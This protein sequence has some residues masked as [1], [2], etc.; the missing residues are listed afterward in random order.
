MLVGDIHLY[1]ILKKESLHVESCNHAIYSC[2]RRGPLGLWR[3]RR[4][5]GWDR[6]DLFLCLSRLVSCQ[7][8]R[9]RTSRQSTCLNRGCRTAKS[10]QTRLSFKP[11]FLPFVV[12]AIVHHWRA[13]PLRR[14]RPRR[15]LCWRLSL[16]RRFAMVLERRESVAFGSQLQIRTTRCLS[17]S[18][19]D[20]YSQARHWHRVK[21]AGCCRIPSKEERG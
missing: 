7:R 6:Q 9:E 11:R 10:A 16:L 14:R 12:L 8:R 21:Q 4:Q 18:V 15:D 2:H 13:S 3:H 20:S 5:S 1:D 19:I 17:E